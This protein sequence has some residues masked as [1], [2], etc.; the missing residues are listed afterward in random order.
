MTDLGPSFNLAVYKVNGPGEPAFISIGDQGSGTRVVSRTTP[1]GGKY[2]VWV[3]GLN[4][5]GSPGTPY[6]LSATVH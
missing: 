3:Y 5:A 4:G 2:Y 1:T 6:T